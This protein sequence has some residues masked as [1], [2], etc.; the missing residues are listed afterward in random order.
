MSAT[1]NQL[2][3]ISDERMKKLIDQTNQVLHSADTT[4]DL[5]RGIDRLEGTQLEKVYAA[6][7]AG[8]QVEIWIKQKTWTVVDGVMP[9]LREELP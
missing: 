9:Y 5:I 1:L 4:M 8:R 6:Y 7:I 3:G 2:L